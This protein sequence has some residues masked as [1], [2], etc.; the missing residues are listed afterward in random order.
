MIEEFLEAVEAARSG[1]IGKDE[2][3][4]RVQKIVSEMN[5]KLPEEMCVL[6]AQGLIEGVDTEELT[7]NIEMIGSRLPGGTYTLPD[8][9]TLELDP[10]EE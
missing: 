9:M 2:L 6:L 4:S 8:K 1:E 10:Y 3:L 5:P 7:W